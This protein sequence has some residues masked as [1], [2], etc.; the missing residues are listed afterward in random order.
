MKHGESNGVSANGVMKY[1][2]VISNGI[3]NNVENHGSA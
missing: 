2:G 1:G 3:N